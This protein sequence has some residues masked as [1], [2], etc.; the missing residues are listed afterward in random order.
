MIFLQTSLITFILQP[1]RFKKFLTRNVLIFTLN[2][3]IFF[4]N[5][6]LLS[7]ENYRAYRF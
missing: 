5:Q 1:M 7:I 6:F 3:D 2:P 4:A